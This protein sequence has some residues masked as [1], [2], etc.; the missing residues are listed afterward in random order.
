MLENYYLL[1]TASLYI[2]TINTLCNG[3]TT[4]APRDAC[5]VA[6]DLIDEACIAS[7]EL[8]DNSTCTAT[9]GSQLATAAAA[10]TTTVS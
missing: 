7:L 2:S 10:C 5:D 3:G 8:G 4:T 1:Q 9:C 6:G